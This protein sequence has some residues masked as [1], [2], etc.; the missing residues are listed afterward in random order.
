MRGYLLNMNSTLND[1]FSLRE[2]H[3]YYNTGYGLLSVKSSM[4]KYDVINLHK[5]CLLQ[6]LKQEFVSRKLQ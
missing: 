3:M 5:S 6:G 1:C 4:D 2:L